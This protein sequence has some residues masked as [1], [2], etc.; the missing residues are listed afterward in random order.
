MNPSENFN[1]QFNL[2]EEM[3][4]GIAGIGKMGI[5]IGLRLLSSGYSVTVWNRTPSKAQSLL[6]AGAQ[7]AASPRLLA[8]SVDVVITLLTN[9]A[10]LDDVY[11]SEDGLLAGQ[12][13]NK[14]FIDMSTVRPAK[15]REMA[16]RTQAVG[17]SFLECPVGGSVGPAKEGKL[18][19]FVGGLSQDLE[20]V[21][22]LLDA[23]CRRVEH[24]G[25][26]G[27]GATMKLAVNLPLMVYWQTLGEALSLVEPLGLD[28]RRVIDIL[29]DSS[30][31]PNMLKVRGD[32]IAQ[33]LGQQKSDLVTVNL[34]TMRKDMQ[35]MLDQGRATHKT[36][37]LTAL[38]L[39]KFD[40]AAQG[41]LDTKDCSELL[42]WWLSQGS[43]A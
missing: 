29:S 3:N 2:G 25:P 27:A 21:R 28:P 43:R 31:G 19:G 6:D 17:A 40:L 15:P 9:E 38:A 33:T 26:Y 1:R 11:G 39:E 13:S 34:S 8:E 10:A 18:L 37:P 41:G 4:I 24:V 35:A 12:V 20:K 32:M 23:M 7:W 30:G 14:M 5:A 16:L 42:V 22:D 36:L